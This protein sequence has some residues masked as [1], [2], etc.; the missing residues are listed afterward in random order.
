MPWLSDWSYPLPAEDLLTWTFD[1]CDYDKDAP[2]YI[3][4]ENP[5]RTLSWN[6]SRSVVRRLIAG[7]R[8]AGIQS[9]DCVMIS[10][11][12]DIYY[13]MLFLAIVGSGGVFTGANPA[14]TSFEI[15]H[16]VKT[17]KAKYIIVEPELL[18]NILEGSSGDVPK[19]NIFIFNVRGQPC[20]EGFKSWTWLLEHG[21]QDWNR[22]T[23]KDICRKT[24][25]ARLTTSGTTGPPKMAVQ[26]HYNA[27]SWFTMVNEISEPPWTITNLSPL[28]LFHVA[29]VPAVH[30]GPLRKGHVM[31]LMRRFDL[32]PYLAAVEKYKISLL[33]MV[34]P[35]VIAIINSP[36]RHKYSLKS[37]RRVGCGAAPL[38]KDSG[39]RLKA[40][41]ADDCTFTQ[42]LGSTETTGV[43]TLFYYP[44][45]DDTG[46]VGNTWFPNSDVK[47]IDDE[48]ND[49]T[50]HDVRGELCV[51]GPSIID[52]YFENEKANRESWDKEGYY[53]TGDIVYRDGKTK[54]FYIVDRKKELIKVRGFQVAP[55]ELEG[56]L[57]GHPDIVDVAVIG[58]PAPRNSDAEL[59]R[60]YIV[61]RP[62]SNN[63]EADVH[64]LVA[65][66]LASYKKLTGGV[67]FVS[68]VPKSASGKIL[69]RVLREEA[70]KEQAAGIGK[71]QSKL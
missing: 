27:T 70:Q 3:D 20:P 67:K 2:I 12:N 19:E 32:E 46:S 35:L 62:G 61:R 15:S 58:L 64:K 66:R 37:V 55:P 22:F 65:E 40:L 25:V 54:K 5:T 56:V 10:S 29:T 63:T 33:G 26:S 57:L 42:V 41:C 51:R 9:G 28:P 11:F 71:L 24:S 1:H 7:F 44:D 68:E 52:G 38:D 6:S 39:E 53:K 34:P 36:L 18:P 31:Y 47:L 13:C 30:C 8:A 21:E 14:Y 17:A 69:K 45:E 23:G 50:A 49:V 60:A 59:P 16:H 43:F 4:L 48:G